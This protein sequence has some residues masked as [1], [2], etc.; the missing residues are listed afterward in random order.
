MLGQVLQGGIDVASK[1]GAAVLGGHTITDPEPKYGM[2][3]LGLAEPERIVRNST[4]PPG[5]HLFLTKPLGIGI[6]TTAHK[7]GV[8]EPELLAA[9]VELM[10]TPNDAAAE[11]MVEAG[12]EAATDVTGFGLL[13]HLQRMLA[14]SGVGATIDASSVPVLPGVLDH[15]MRD[16]VPGGTKRNHAYLGPNVDWGELSTPEQL[17]LAD[18][19][20]SGGLLIATLDPERT[21]RELT[22][23]RRRVGGHRARGRGRA[24]DDRRHRPARAR[25]LNL[26]SGNTLV[27]V[28]LLHLQ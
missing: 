28:R 3:A 17:V 10:T 5:A 18:A 7:R 12:A 19:Q 23:P 13:G 4:V 22:L 11:A 26:G 15:A 25:R 9:A 14:A 27:L 2:V 21:A 20:T 6:A 24:R 1:A 16:V 8:A